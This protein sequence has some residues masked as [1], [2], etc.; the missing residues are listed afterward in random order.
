MPAF[1]QKLK[2]FLICYSSSNCT[3][4]SII[5]D[6][7]FSLFSVNTVPCLPQSCSYCCVSLTHC[8]MSVLNSWTILKSVGLNAC[9]KVKLGV[10]QTIDARMRSQT[11][12]HPV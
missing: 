1:W 7:A 6:S 11:S 10:M 3:F 9:I 4:T 8:D 5:M 12:H 2:L